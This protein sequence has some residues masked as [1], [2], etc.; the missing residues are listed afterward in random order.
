M[1]SLLSILFPRFAKGCHFRSRAKVR[2]DLMLR[3]AWIDYKR[4]L[5]DIEASQ[6]KNA[7]E[8]LRDN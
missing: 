4:E 2:R 1:L 3:L 8:W 7:L 5:H 6:I